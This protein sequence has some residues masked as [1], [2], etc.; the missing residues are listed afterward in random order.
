[1]GWTRDA[2]SAI[3]QARLLE[4]ALA[5][6]EP[7]KPTREDRKAKLRASFASKVGTESLATRAEVAA[8]LDVSVKTVQRMK[9]E[10]LPRCRTSKGVVRY[11]T[12]GVQ[13][14]AKVSRT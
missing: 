4:L 5:R 8:Y 13:R 12:G 11:P 9:P 10:V 7:S 1:M 3:Y 6:L 2:A 14:L